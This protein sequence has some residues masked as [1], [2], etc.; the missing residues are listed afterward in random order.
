[1]IV[2]IDR[3]PVPWSRPAG[4]NR[5][6]SP[7][8]EAWQGIVKDAVEQELTANG[9]K[10]PFDGPFNVQIIVH[11]KTVDDLLAYR[12]DGDNIAKAILDA[13]TGTVWKDDRLA[14][15][16]I[17]SVKAG[18]ATYLDQ[19]FTRIRFESASLPTAIVLV[20]TARPGASDSE[21]KG[22]N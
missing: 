3:L 7:E 12:G 15:I 18:A 6:K 2:T 8:L 10:G 13:L 9:L 20:P 21:P 19:E 5:H 4:E 16:P 14:T 1:M 22:M 17:Q 11:F